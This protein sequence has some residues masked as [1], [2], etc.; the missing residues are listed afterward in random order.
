[1]W[2]YAGGFSGACIRSHI[3]VYISI[4]I[5]LCNASM[6]MPHS[7]LTAIVTRPCCSHLQQVRGTGAPCQW[8][9]EDRHGP[10]QHQCQAS[11][12]HDWWDNF[13]TRVRVLHVRWSM[14]KGI[15]ESLIDLAK[16]SHQWG[17]FISDLKA[18]PSYI[19]LFQGS[20]SGNTQPRAKFPS[21]P[22]A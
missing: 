12:G 18:R 11:D 10:L 5:F 21:L 17:G 22:C 14:S 15:A 6:S 16:S 8:C 20:L 19:C 3:F 13:I 4:A 2:E 1:M 7:A 9:V